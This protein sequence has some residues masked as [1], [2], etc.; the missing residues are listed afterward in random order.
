MLIDGA[1]QVGKTHIVREFAHE[2]Y[3]H[4]AEIN[5]IENELATQAVS[6]ATTAEELFTRILA[7][8]KDELVP[9]NTLV[10]LDEIQESKKT[11]TAIKLLVDEFPEYDWIL[12]GSLLGL[13]LK[14]IR[15]VPVGYL[16]S[17]TM[18]PLDFE[19]FC[20]ANSEL[21]Q[22][23]KRFVISDVEGKARFDRYE[24]DFMWLAD[25]G[26]ALPV[27]NV[28]APRPPLTISQNSSLFKLF[29]SD[30]G[31]LS[32]LC[33]MDV[34]REMLA[35]RRDVLYGA[36]YENVVAQELT[37]HGFPLYYFRSGAI[38]ELDFLVE[39]PISTVLPIEVKSGKTYKRHNA[40]KNV[41]KVENYNI[42]QAL[43]L[44]EQNLE[45][46]DKVVYAPIYCLMFLNGKNR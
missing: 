5:F 7:F 27:Y 24:N 22:Q 13:E 21:S 18:H 30:V 39:Y 38:G 4:F 46:E 16:D 1:R 10:F 36:L 8:V 37:A 29:L 43:V 19:E 9:G 41:L 35:G 25:A 31:L 14:N 26:V 42:N 15:S 6:T 11:P 28:S 20:W 23:N 40:L 12:S 32:Y 45:V 34:T 3:E 2:N 17:F 44:C 33:G